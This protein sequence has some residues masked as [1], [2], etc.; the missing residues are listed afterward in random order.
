MAAYANLLMAK[1]AIGGHTRMVCELTLTDPAS[2]RPTGAFWTSPRTLHLCSG[3]PFLRDSTSTTGFIFYESLVKDWG[4]TLQECQIGEAF[5]NIADVQLILHNKKLAAQVDN[6]T[7][8]FSSG[9]GIQNPQLTGDEIKLSDIFNFYSAI[10]AVVTIKVFFFSEASTDQSVGANF[11]SDTLY[12]GLVHSIRLEGEEIILDLVQDQTAIETLLPGR[13]LDTSPVKELQVQR[14]PIA[15]GDYHQYYNVGQDY[16][17]GLSLDACIAARLLTPTVVPL[18]PWKTDSLGRYVAGDENSRFQTW[19]IS[20]DTLGR[21]YPWDR[22]DAYVGKPD[23]EDRILVY[24]QDSDVFGIILEGDEASAVSGQTYWPSTAPS[25]TEQYVINHGTLRGL[26]Y[27]PCSSVKATNA[28]GILSNAERIFDGSPWTSASLA[29]DAA[30]WVELRFRPVNPLGNTHIIDGAIRAFV[31]LDTSTA[32]T[33]TKLKFGLYRN[34]TGTTYDGYWGNGPVESHPAKN[35]PGYITAASSAFT[36]GMYD[37]NDYSTDDIPSYAYVRDSGYV[38]PFTQWDWKCSVGG[39]DLSELLL[40]IEVDVTGA[41]SQVAKIIAAGIIVRYVP[42]QGITQVTKRVIRK[43][44]ER[45]SP[46][47]SPGGKPRFTNNLENVPITLWLMPQNTMRD[48]LLALGSCGTYSFTGVCGTNLTEVT[49]LPAHL[50]LK[51]GEGVTWV[52]TATPVNYSGA[53]TTG[54]ANFGSSVYAASM[55]DDFHVDGQGLTAQMIIDR[56]TTM[57]EAISN[58]VGQWPIAFYRDVMTGNYLTIGYPGNSPASINRY[59]GDSQ[60]EFHPNIDHPSAE[61]YGEPFSVINLRVRQANA[62]EIF[63][64]FR[65][66]YHYFAPTDS[67]TF[68]Q[69]VT[70][71]PNDCVVYNFSTNL[72]DG[73]PAAAVSTLGYD[74]SAVCATSQA[75]YGVKRWLPTLDCPSIHTHSMANVVMNYIVRRFSQTRNIIECTV[76]TEAYDLKPGHFVR[77]SK[78]LNL[79]YPYMDYAFEGAKKKGWDWDSD[80]ASYPNNDYIVMSVTK[81]PYDHGVFVTFTC[82]QIMYNLSGGSFWTP[83][84]DTNCLSWLRADDISGAVEGD[85]IATWT[86]LVGQDATQSTGANKP[87]YRAA[88]GSLAVNGKACVEFDGTNDSMAIGSLGNVDAGAAS[89]YMFAF[90]FNSDTGASGTHSPMGFRHAVGDRIYV[91]HHEAG[92][93]NFA[94]QNG[95]T[96]RDGGADGTTGWQV[97]VVVCDSTNGLKFYRNGTQVGSTGTYAQVRLSNLVAAA[98]GEDSG[99]ANY[100]DGKI[101]QAGVTKDVTDATRYKYE[102]MLAHDI[103]IETSLPTNHTYRFAPPVVG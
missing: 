76:G 95:A 48:R 74:A 91:Y 24:H 5:G 82:E 94:L 46:D 59:W 56:E 1:R 77:F 12:S 65:I 98:I 8:A 13:I 11:L 25:E 14:A 27:V 40:K 100:F 57:R 29:V 54:G 2:H 4:Q 61:H 50:M 96:L 53:A 41:A 90:A 64:R 88:T 75:R 44:I 6:S 20:N 10:S 45:Y 99:A 33:G 35:T 89:N 17:N 16:T 32:T 85:A 58:L 60:I 47:A 101:R 37:Q 7:Y 87:T 31:I 21:N 19:Y 15:Y 73:T 63:N 52:D 102:G 55:I 81:Q 34:A 30:N 26:A 49:M 72:N 28:D 51:F 68:Q 70:E 83:A 71:A 84:N 9:S 79:V 93:T 43:V 103:G 80:A 66:R 39:G 62:D 38:E 86:K 22:Q 3:Q 36:K 23:G 18:L 92:T 67:Y 69:V 97:F 78:D 42:N